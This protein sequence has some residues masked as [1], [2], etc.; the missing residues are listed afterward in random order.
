MK[1]DAGRKPAQPQRRQLIVAAASIA[2][3]AMALQS[4]A[5]AALAEESSA[6]NDLLAKMLAALG[7]EIDGQVAMTNAALELHLTRILRAP[8]MCDATV[9]DLKQRILQNI[10]ADYKSGAIGIVD[11]WWLSQTEAHCLELIEQVR[12]G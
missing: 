8:T 9:P 5:I 11:G 6:G 1:Q 4:P 2:G 3:I 7:Q 12:A 10:E